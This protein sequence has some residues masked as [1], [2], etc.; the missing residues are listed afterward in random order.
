M[1]KASFDIL[2]VDDNRDLAQNIQDVFD[3]QGYGTAI[4]FDGRSAIELCR[5]R[6]FD[7]VLID[8]QLP[9][10][11]GLRLQE[12]LA[13]LTPAEYLIITGHSSVESAVAVVN[14]RQILGYETKPVDL[15]HL[16]ALIHQ[17]SERKQAEEE[18]KKHRE[19]L[20]ELVKERTAALQQEIEEH[21]RT[22]TTLRHAQ[23][24]ALEALQTAETANQLKSQF[25]ANMSHDIRTPMNSVIGFAEILQERLRGFPQYHSYLDGILDGGRTLLHLIDEILD[26]ARIEAGQLDI[27][28]EAVNLPAVLYEMQQ[29]FALKAGKKGIQLTTQI[30]PDTPRTVLLDG[31]RLRQILMNLVGNAV[32]FTEKGSVTLRVTCQECKSEAFA[33]QS[34]ALTLLFE[35]E[36]TGIGIP[37][38]EQA[39][40]FEAFQQHAPE[41]PGGTGLGL[42][43]TKRLVE[44][45]HG[46]I[47]VES[48]VNAGARFRVLLTATEIAALA[49]DGTAGKELE[50]IHFHGATILL[51]EDDA[52]NREVVRAYLTSYDLHLIE[53]ENGQEAI[54]MLTPG[55]AG[56]SPAFPSR[57]GSGVGFRPDLI[58]MDIR[59]PVMDGYAATQRLKTDPELRAIPVVALTAYAL[60]EQKEKYQDIYDAYLSKP[61]S[62]HDLIATLAKFLPHTKAP[63]TKRGQEMR[64]PSLTGAQEGVE[65][66]NMLEKLKDYAAQTGPFPQALLD[67]LRVELLP[68][69]KEISEVMS[70]ERMIGFAEAIITVGDAFTN[71][72]LKAYGEELLR[73]LKVFDVITMKRLLAVFPEFVAL[74]TDRPA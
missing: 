52:G 20:E 22:E 19:H 65:A 48:K 60:K 9:D 11:D 43:I 54:Q 26:L 51:V 1:Q 73:A 15:D 38:D 27:R 70:L 41:I 39:R 57:E 53:A 21:K 64:I 34:S 74:M 72:P 31:N 14:R 55:S 44:L 40:I 4:A 45:M 69:H 2:I 42:A 68:K 33:C 63:G 50:Q 71:P 16:R 24:T 67:T 10:M 62:R 46:T 47:A 12:Q 7:L 18:L 32:K 28:P 58:L 8:I 6:E 35:I 61:I 29:M 13:E 23:V 49:E 59:M 17:I 66:R 3:A 25:L 37:Q 36:D 56:V 5:Q 30:S